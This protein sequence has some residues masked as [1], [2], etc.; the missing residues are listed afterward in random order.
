M[1][2]TFN[3]LS[4]FDGVSI[5]QLALK[6]AGISVS[7]YFA[8]EI[9]RHA[10]KVT[11]HHFPNT[12]Q[13]GCVTTVHQS[14]LPKIDLLLGGSPCQGFSSAGKKLAFDD[15]RSKLFFEYVRIL[16]EC[17]SNNP[18]LLFLLEN[19]KMDKHSEDEITKLLGVSPIMIDSALVSGQ[20]RKRLYWTNIPNVSQPK[21]LG[22]KMI[23]ILDLSLIGDKEWYDRRISL[24]RW[25]KIQSIHEKKSRCILTQDVFD[26]IL[27]ELYR[28]LTPEE[29]E[30]LQ[31]FP[32]GYTDILTK[33]Q[34]YKEIGNS[35]TVDVI[36]HIFKNI[37]Q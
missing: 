12:K 14:N 33:T 25:N 26:T 21:D 34:R 6:K 15:D 13:L 31:T 32:V 22:I 2:E 18:K 11:Q 35:W 29:C 16:N 17:R 7:N 37:K 20:S 28:Y 3:V 1:K 27:V 4:L 9:D 24:K 30:K 36:T 23:D 8:S 10:I 19:V 5:G